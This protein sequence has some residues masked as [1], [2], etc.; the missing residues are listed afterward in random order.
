MLRRDPDQFTV[1][2]DATALTDGSVTRA[3]LAEP[4]WESAEHRGLQV[5]RYYEVILNRPADPDGRLNWVKHMMNGMTEDQ[6]L[7]AFITSWE[8]HL[9]HPS[10][11]NF[12][13]GLYEDIL[14]RQADSAGLVAW[15]T[16]L[17]QY[18]TPE[19][20]IPLPGGGTIG[21][22]PGGAAP[23]ANAFL[24]SH[25]R[26]ANI[27]AAVYETYLGRSADEDGRE[28]WATQLDSGAMD[29][30]GLIEAFITSE[31]FKNRVQSSVLTTFTSPTPIDVGNDIH[32]IHFYDI[33]SPGDPDF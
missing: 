28:F 32:R 5:D 2:S 14:G 23:L 16:A 8:Y 25:E 9:Q 22:I 19:T 18:P 31:E 30:E 10:D 29:D 33:R 20:Q 26:N 17:D 15:E 6:I 21:A 7:T 11:T 13:K 24:N 12:V 4:V 3:E 1:N 27:V